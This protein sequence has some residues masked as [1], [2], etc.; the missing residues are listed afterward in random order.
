MDKIITD[1]FADFK[2]YLTENRYEID[3]INKTS[4][5]GIKEKLTIHLFKELLFDKYVLRVVNDGYKI[6]NTIFIVDGDKF[7]LYHKDDD[8]VLYDLFDIINYTK[9]KITIQ[10]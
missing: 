1:L 9:E 5:R 8:R 3:E 6:Y 2:R 4:I 7:R 10:I